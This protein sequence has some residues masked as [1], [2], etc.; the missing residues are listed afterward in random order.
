MILD[1]PVRTF[2]DK[3]GFA[4]TLP[5]LGRVGWGLAAS[6]GWLGT[7][8]FSPLHLTGLN[9]SV[10][11]TE[12]TVWGGSAMYPWPTADQQPWLV[13]SS[14]NDDGAPAGTGAWVVRV[15]WMNSVG[16]E[17]YEDVTLN[18][19]G[20]VQMVASTVRRINRAEVLTCG[21]TGSNE[22]TITIYA[23]DAATVIGV[24]PPLNTT[25]TGVGALNGCYQTV[26]AGYQDVLQ[27]FHCHAIDSAGRYR[28]LVRTTST[29]PWIPKAW[30]YPYSYTAPIQLPPLVIPAGA[31]Y[32]VVSLG[33][34]AGYGWA[35][36]TGWREPT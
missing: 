14:V 12:E 4:A 20:N 35:G 31:D 30:S 18:G 26:P 2:L 25:A 10:A 8:T 29:S 23:T 13:S 33:T 3:I 24:I 19:V 27:Q 6:Q 16:V 22:G 28:L 9:A 11:V 7:G 15:W 32:M 17:A 36:L 1:G 21:V 5:V 34:A